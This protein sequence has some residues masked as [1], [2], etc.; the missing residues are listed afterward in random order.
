M[1]FWKTLKILFGI[2]LNIADKTTKFWRQVYKKTNQSK[3]KTTFETERK[4]ADY[5]IFSVYW[6]KVRK[7][8]EN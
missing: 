1:Q 2:T 7:K 6:P 3:E 5:E 4:A 8:I